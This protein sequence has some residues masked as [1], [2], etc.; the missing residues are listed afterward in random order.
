MKSIILLFIVF[1]IINA[2]RVRVA[3]A[4][5]EAPA[6]DILVNDNLVWSSVYYQTITNYVEVPGGMCFD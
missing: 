5:F 4:C 6:V 1:T 2:A 3:H